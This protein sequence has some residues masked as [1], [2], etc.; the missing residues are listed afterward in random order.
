MLEHGIFPRGLAQPIEPNFAGPDCIQ[1][2]NE[3]ICSPVKLVFN[4]IR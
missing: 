1:H 4:S 2:A 3:D